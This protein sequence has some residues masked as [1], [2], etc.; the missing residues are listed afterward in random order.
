MQVSPL[1]QFSLKPDCL[2]GSKTCTSYNSKVS[3]KGSQKLLQQ[4]GV[5]IKLF[6][7]MSIFATLF[8]QKCANT[9]EIRYYFNKT[10]TL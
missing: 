2:F 1:S 10:S 5:F 3:E 9:E 8:K 6:F 7:T 4:S